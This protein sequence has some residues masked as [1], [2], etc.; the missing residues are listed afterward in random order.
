MFQQI[1]LLN[2]GARCFQAAEELLPEVPDY[3]YKE[4]VTAIY[5]HVNP[6]KGCKLIDRYAEREVAEHKG[7]SHG[8][9]MKNGLMA[10][11]P[12]ITLPIFRSHPIPGLVCLAAA[13]KIRNVLLL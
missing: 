8:Q 7:Y 10:V 5:L 1:L 9:A 3:Y 2:R 11:I 13:Y 6:A 4:M 12:L